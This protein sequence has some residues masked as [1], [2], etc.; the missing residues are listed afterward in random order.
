MAKGATTATDICLAQQIRLAQ[1]QQHYI[2]Y[3]ELAILL[4]LNVA[5]ILVHAWRRVQ[6]PRQTYVWPI[7]QLLNQGQLL[8]SALKLMTVGSTP[9]RYIELAILITLNVALI[10]VHCMRACVAKGATTATDICLVHPQ[11]RPHL[12]RQLPAFAFA[13]LVG[14]F[15]LRILPVRMQLK[16]I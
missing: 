15:A 10:L 14:T 16:E 13:E 9:C 2:L 6:R 4:T 8:V 1:I 11:E 5:I 7:R 3:W 12:R